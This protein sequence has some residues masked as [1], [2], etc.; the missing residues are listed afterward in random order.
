MEVLRKTARGRLSE[1]FGKETL[2][3]DQL[4]RELGISDVQ[5]TDVNEE[6][7]ESL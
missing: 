5:E 7:L 1:I 3:V 2:R 6:V 4:V